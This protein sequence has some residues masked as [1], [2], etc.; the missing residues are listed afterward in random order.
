MTIFITG[1]TSSIGRVLIKRL[2]GENQAVRV[3]VRP[4]SDRRGLERP[5]I[6]FVPGDVTD[7]A[8]VSRGMLGCDRV[9]HLAAVVGG[10]VPD[11]TWWKVNRDGTRHVLQAALDLGI[12]SMVQVSTIGVLG[13]TAP[14]ELADERRSI[15]LSS[16]TNLYQKT[17][18]AAD[19]MAHSFVALGLPV[20]IVYPCFGYGC[21]WA[22]SHPSMAEMTLLRLAYGKPAAI[23]GSG[24]NHLTLSYYKDTAQGILL[25]LEKGR[26]G[27]DYI[28]GGPNLTFNEIWRGVAAILH[29]SPPRLHLPLGLLNLAM[30]AAKTLTGAQFLPPDFIDM[31]ALNWNYSSARAQNELGWKM[32]PFLTALAETWSE[33]QRNTY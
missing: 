22:S 20:K 13:A 30:R 31:V 15:D 6:E 4:A 33:Y 14:G 8:S 10:S 18:R 25:A 11:E 5:G 17:K 28:L 26:D 2:A 19:E 23:M 3:L 24:K 1:G 27:R 32:T 12:K 29:K 21:S 7:P 16:Y 9:V